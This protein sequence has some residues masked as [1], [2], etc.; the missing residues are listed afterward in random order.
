MRLEVVKVEIRLGTFWF[1]PTASTGWNEAFSGR[2]CSRLLVSTNWR[3]TRAGPL[4]MLSAWQRKHNSYS[5]V[6]GV[7]TAP[8]ALIPVTPAIAPEAFGAR[9][10]VVL[11]ACGLWQSAHST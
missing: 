9:A 8:S 1:F 7:T 10:G 2:N 3:G 11:A 6:S 4:A 5:A